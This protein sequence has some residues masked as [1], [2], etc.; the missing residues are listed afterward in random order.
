MTPPLLPKDKAHN[1]VALLKADPRAMAFKYRQKVE[2][3]RID[4]GEVAAYSLAG[5]G[6]LDL[7]ELDRKSVV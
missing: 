3:L 5:S 6:Y 2:S 4:V 1:L 7:Y